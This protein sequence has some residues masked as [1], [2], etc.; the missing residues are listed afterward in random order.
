MKM[1]DCQ[2]KT[3]YEPDSLEVIYQKKIQ[4]IVDD[5]N[6][7]A[8]VSPNYS[9]IEYRYFYKMIKDLYAE[10]AI[11]VLKKFKLPLDSF[12][13]KDN[14]DFVLGWWSKPRPRGLLRRL[15]NELESSNE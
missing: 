3:Y 7:Y 1:M 2:S 11:K 12:S 13:Y 15:F 9:V 5:A 8:L 6:R 14:Y 4:I 10:Y